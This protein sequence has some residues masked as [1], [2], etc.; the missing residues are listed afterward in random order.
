M[1]V[2]GRAFNTLGGRLMARSGRVGILASTG[3]RTGRRRTAPLGFVARP[4]GTV[5]VVAGSPGP[6]WAG[7]LLA[8]PSCTFA[9]RGRERRYRA[10]LLE[11]PERDEALV[12]VR[13]AWGRMAE[14]ATFGETFALEPEG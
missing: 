12:A 8:Q 14:R 4:D 11:G 6:A 2:F 9:I 10:R 1:N 13:V 7:N 3:R 5:L